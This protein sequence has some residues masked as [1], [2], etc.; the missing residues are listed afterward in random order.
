[1]IMEV[2][3][4]VVVMVDTVVEAMAA[5]MADMVEVDTVEATGWVVC[6]AVKADS[7]PVLGGRYLLAAQE[8]RLQSMVCPSMSKDPLAVAMVAVWEVMVEVTVMAVM[9]CLGGCNL[10]G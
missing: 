4:M 8:Q 7:S 3:V 1:M 10:G 2:A 5:V 6:M 9:E